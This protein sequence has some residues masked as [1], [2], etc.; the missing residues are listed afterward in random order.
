MPEPIYWKKAQKYLSIKDKKLSKII[1]QY[2]GHLKTRNNPFYSLCKAIVGQ[3]ISVQSAD[4]VWKRFSNKC[5]RISPKNVESL[6]V[7]EIRDC[8]ITRQKTEYIKLL[9]A[10]FV[11]KNF[12]AS[13]LK[14]L[15]DEEAICYLC[16][17]K[18]IGKW[19]A[20]MF[21]IFNQNRQ[22][23]FPIQDIGLLKGISRA[24]GTP[25]PPSQ[26]VLDKFRKKWSPFCTVATW[27]MWRSVDPVVVEY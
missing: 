18:G 22:N 25:Y 12:K 7:Q 5:K 3:Q 21:L 2:K 11:N 9:S 19:T 6:T 15:N 13:E 17:N 14:N 27:Y 16:K 26:R 4:S 24:Y 23:L 8:G 20:E 1:S 10:N